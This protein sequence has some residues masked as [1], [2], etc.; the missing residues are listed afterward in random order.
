[1]K[2]IQRKKL[3]EKLSAS[4]QDVGSSASAP[5]AGAS[6]AA[7]KSKEQFEIQNESLV[8]STIGNLRDDS[9]LTKWIAFGQNESSKDAITV[10]GSGSGGVDEL[11]EYFKDSEIAFGLLSVLVE[12]KDAGEEYKTAKVIFISWVGPECKPLVK[13][14][15]SQ[16]RLSLYNFIKKSITVSG[17]FQALSSGDLTTENVFQ[18][19]RYN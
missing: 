15:S 18:K 12:E 13:A 3:L 8:V 17:E 1:V 9:N 14:R 19:I 5:S 10:L 11:K 6:K 4:R 7:A 2:N 16:I